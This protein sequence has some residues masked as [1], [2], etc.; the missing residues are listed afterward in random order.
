MGG[1]YVDPSWALHSYLP[2]SMFRVCAMCDLGACSPGP[3]AGHPAPHNI[4]TTPATA[5]KP[6]IYLYVPACSGVCLIVTV[7]RVWLVGC[8]TSA[9]PLWPCTTPPLQPRAPALCCV[10]VAHVCPPP[11]RA[12]LFKCVVIALPPPPPHCPNL[13]WFVVV[14]HAASCPES[15]YQYVETCP[16]RSWLVECVT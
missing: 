12:F 10:C 8:C 11:A 6:T 16:L 13:S 15:H 14:V 9:C 3:A 1:G 2:S 5:G 4:P 7:P